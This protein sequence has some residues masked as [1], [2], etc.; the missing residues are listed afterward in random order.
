V[1]GIVVTTAFGLA[2]LALL[3][4]VLAPDLQGRS[5]WLAEAA[6]FAPYGWICWLVAVLVGLVSARRRLAVLPLALG[7]A[8][9]SF[10]LLPYLPGAPSAVAGQRATLGILTLNLRFGLADP[11]RLAAEVDRRRPDVVVLTEV[12]DSTM[13]ALSTKP[14]RARLPYRLGTTDTDADPATGS[15][16]AGGTMILSRFALTDL[17]RARDTAFTNLAARVAMPEHPFVLV[18][19]HPASPEHGLSRWLQ[20]GQSIAALASAHTSEPLVVAGDLNA[21]AEHLTLRELKARAGLTDTSTG[22]GWHATYPADTWYPPLIQID[23]VLV[24]SAFTTTGLDTFGVPGTD[25]R[26]LMVQLAVS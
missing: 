7:L 2:G 8:V 5:Q 4:V 3:L 14:W 1:P 9:H 12:T 25:H 10:L 15:G 6:S 23:H 16:G 11:E 18:G 19:T 13:K 20:D 21:T 26:G 22:R 17:G 24:S